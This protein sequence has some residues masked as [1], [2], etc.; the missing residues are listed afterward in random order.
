MPSV[1]QSLVFWSKEFH[2]LNA[3]GREEFKRQF[4]LVV[5]YS[6]WD[7][8]RNI[9]IAV[10]HVVVARF[11]DI[12]VQDD[13]KHLAKSMFLTS[14]LQCFETWFVIKLLYAT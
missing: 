4:V 13:S 14:F 12:T 11:A 7:F 8:V 2:S 1:A 3:V 6:C 9:L 10:V 5:L